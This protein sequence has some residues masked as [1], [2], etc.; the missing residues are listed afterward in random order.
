[1]A[2]TPL[3]LD[4]RRSIRA[5]NGGGV[6]L[7]PLFFGHRHVLLRIGCERGN[8]GNIRNHI[9]VATASNNGVNQSGQTIADGR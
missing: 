4:R 7:P 9:S 8:A 3:T 6:S 2:W 1:M 5:A